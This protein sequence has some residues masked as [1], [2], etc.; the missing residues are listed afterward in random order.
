MVRRNDGFK[1][2]QN[3]TKAWKAAFCV[4]LSFI[5]AVSPV[6]AYATN[7][8]QEEAI[9]NSQALFDSAS[10]LAQN[11]EEKAVISED[12]SSKT[13]E[14]EP[15]IIGE[16]ESLR[17]PGIKHFRLSD[18]SFMVADYGMP[19]HYEA[20]DGTLKDIDNTLIRTE[21]GYEPVASALDIVLPDDLAVG[22]GARLDDGEHPISWKHDTVT[23]S[24]RLDEPIKDEAIEVGSIPDAL[25]ESVGG[26]EEQPAAEIKPEVSSEVEASTEIQSQ[27]LPDIEASAEGLTTAEKAEIIKVADLDTVL[28]LVQKDVART[29]LT[30]NEQ[31]TTL[32]KLTADV[33]YRGVAKG[34]GLEYTTTPLGVKENIVLKD[35]TAP[36]EHIVTYRVGDLKPE[37]ADDQT[38]RL[39]DGDGSAVWTISAPLMTDENGELS[40]SITMEIVETFED[41]V[42]IRISA[43]KT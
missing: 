43:D 27:A 7:P 9:E 12:I 29:T 8:S 15:Y 32:K 6:Q 10:Q 22:E 34:V 16:E 33:T 37:Q 21:R 36:A 18:G 20:E 17:E 30:K 40:F 13:S 26:L 28:E 1:S 35:R 42:K 5:L 24:S 23:L 39:L 11:L 31:F 25:T 2:A 38:V 19:V 14:E 4:A 41:S 3:R